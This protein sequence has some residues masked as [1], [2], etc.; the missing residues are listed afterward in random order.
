MTKTGGVC[1]FDLVVFGNVV[2][3]FFFGKKLWKRNEC[4][5]VKEVMVVYILGFVF[6]S[7]IVRCSLTLSWRGFYEVYDGK[8]EA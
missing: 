7:G 2:V 1:V 8:G 5:L 6:C 3:F 4:F